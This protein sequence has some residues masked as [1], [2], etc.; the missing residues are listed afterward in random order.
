MS[1]AL[2]GR[3]FSTEPP[4]KP[5]D[6]FTGCL[7]QALPRVLETQHI[8]VL[9]ELALWLWRTGS[10]KKKSKYIKKQTAAMLHTVGRGEKQ[11]RWGGA[12]RLPDQS[13]LCRALRGHP[14]ETRAPGQE[15]WPASRRALPRQ[16]GR[17]AGLPPRRSILV[18]EE[19]RSPALLFPPLPIKERVPLH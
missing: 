3:F 6:S 12:S 8:P 13:R 17:G 7:N 10:L 2:A 1:P 14:A 4:G 11:G 5:Q 15:A 16:R 18:R 9:V 19:G